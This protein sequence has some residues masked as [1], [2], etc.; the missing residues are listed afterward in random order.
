MERNIEKLN[1]V[2]P[3]DVKFILNTLENAGYEGFAV[4]GCVRDVCLG[5]TPK[6]WDITTSAKPEEIKALFRRTVDTGIEH[7]T[8]TVMLEKTGYEV[9]TYRIDGTYSDA[10]HPDG[11]TFTEDIT[12]DLRRRDFTINAMAY[13]E[14]RGL[15]DPY[16]GIKDL[17]AG[18]IRAVGCAA[19]RF[20]EDALRI[21]RAVRFASQLGF[22]IEEET[23]RAM[24]AKAEGLTKVSAERIREE[25]VKLIMGDRPELLGLMYEL[26]ITDIVFPEWNEVINTTQENR[27][28]LYTVADHTLVAMH[29]LK[30]LIESDEE[31][32]HDIKDYFDVISEAEAEVILS[33]KVIE[34]R[35]FG[36]PDGVY[37]YADLYLYEDGALDI[38]GYRIPEVE[39]WLREVSR[40]LSEKEK[41]MLNLAM[42]FHDLGKSKTKTYDYE[43]KECHFSGHAE[44]SA[45]MTKKILTRLKF[46]NE[47]IDMV[48]YL[49]QNHD[50]WYTHGWE[51]GSSTARRL[52]NRMG[53]DAFRIIMFI[54]YSDF[55]AH[56]PICLYKSHEKMK[57]AII[58]ID[59]VYDSHAAVCVKELA[60]NGKDLIAMGFETGPKLGQALNLLLEEVLEEPG[61][62]EREYLISRAKMLK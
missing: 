34:N 43:A 45:D 32:P 26:G 55:L 42:L 48:K 11:V 7:G 12:E 33:R 19:E 16:E 36:S 54:Q 10:R 28:H 59:E 4:G 38:S 5:R 17:E 56:S 14:K 37:N 25:L 1:I 46:D 15:C 3:E 50:D 13:N 31:K 44:V 24:Q 27:N 22:E 41:M 23:L 8:V 40:T 21:M 53:M 39:G 51:R 2:L 62:N 47:T 52:A 30:R 60:I 35:V 29:E 9:T 61:R 49:V 57:N 20:S 6:D 58:M 18:I